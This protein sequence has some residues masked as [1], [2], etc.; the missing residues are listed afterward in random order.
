M[1]SLF[2]KLLKFINDLIERF[3][4]HRV[5]ASAAH[6]AFF[7]M[8]SFIP[9]IILLFSLLQFTGIEKVDVL[10]A[11]QRRVPREMQ[12]FCTGVISEA[13]SKTATTISLSALATLWSA[14]RGMM[15]LTEGLQWIAEIREERNYI[16][17]RIRSTFYTV[18]FLLLIIVFLLL[19]VFGNALMKLL[20]TRFPVT[21]YAVEM[22]RDVKNIFLLL[23][24]VVIFALIYKFMP[25]EH[26]PMKYHMPGAFISSIGWFVFS[27]LFSIY[28]DEYNGFADMY[29]SLTT[30]VLVMLWLYFGMY[31]TLI[32]SEANHMLAEF[33]ERR[34]KRAESRGKNT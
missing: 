4:R 3:A 27:Y 33:L 26:K 5:G 20:V 11:I 10:V 13:Y 29:G 21:V 19:G 18:V 16:A 23:F 28:V 25:G 15:A 8:L 14:G 1:K 24:A 7:I 6:T 17:V 32:G 12:V 31:I 30:I 22:I 9:C 34:K 2:G